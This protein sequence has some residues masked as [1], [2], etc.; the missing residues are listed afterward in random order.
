MNH[1]DIKNGTTIHD[2]V[3]CPEGWHDGS[4]CCNCKNQ[5]ELFKHPW[6]K[7]NKGPISESTNMYACIAQFDCDKVPKGIIF[8][9]KHGMCEM[10]IRMD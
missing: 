6:N 5:I 4:C 10:Y 2:K 9:K 7:I 8:E 3:K 1:N